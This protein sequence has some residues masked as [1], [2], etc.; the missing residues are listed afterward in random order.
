MV[1]HLPVSVDG[2]YSGMQH[3][4]TLL[5][6]EG[7]GKYVNLMQGDRPEDF[8][9]EVARETQRT[10]SNDTENECARLFA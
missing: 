1:S 8:Y 4:S 7:C 10:V 2:T 9:A 3:Y 6:D 5:K